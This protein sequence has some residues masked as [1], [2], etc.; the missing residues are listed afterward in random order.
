MLPCLSLIVK[1]KK[2]ISRQCVVKTSCGLL[3]LYQSVLATKE[4]CYGKLLKE[5]ITLRH[6]HHIMTKFRMNISSGRYPPRHTF[7]KK[8]IHIVEVFA[9]MSLKL[10]CVHDTMLFLFCFVFF[11]KGNLRHQYHK[12]LYLFSLRKTNSRLKKITLQ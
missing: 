10:H 2:V 5:W 1:W 11:W 7:K 3:S 12:Y 9:L 8:N 6:F 4:Q